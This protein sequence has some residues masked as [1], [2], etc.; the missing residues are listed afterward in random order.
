MRWGW[1]LRNTLSKLI[2]EEPGLSPDPKDGSETGGQSLGWPKWSDRSPNF[3]ILSKE[4]N[5]LFNFTFLQQIFNACLECTTFSHRTQVLG[6]NTGFKQ[7]PA[8]SLKGRNG[9]RRGKKLAYTLYARDL[10]SSLQVGRLDK[11]MG[12]MMCGEIEEKMSR[13]SL[14]YSLPSSQSVGNFYH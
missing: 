6:G 12:D 7:S 3:Y 2:S 1:R 11:H 5:D 9:G 8:P 13:Y 14:K 10:P 4:E